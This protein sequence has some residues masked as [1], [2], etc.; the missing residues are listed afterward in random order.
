MDA[1]PIRRQAFALAKQ[2]ASG[3]EPLEFLHLVSGRESL[4]G[5]SGEA[6]WRIVL[7]LRA[8]RAAGRSADSD[9]P[10]RCEPAQWRRICW[11]RNQMGWSDDRLDGF[12]QRQLHIDRQALDTVG[13]RAIITGLEQIRR[14]AGRQDGR[15]A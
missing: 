7:E 5:L 11:M 1:A 12:I 15:G 10:P 13:A 8:R 9:T 3:M 6:W 14:K 2:L 4:K